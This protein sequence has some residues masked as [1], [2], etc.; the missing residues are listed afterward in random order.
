MA[1]REGLS[2]F[3][4]LIGE[5]VLIQL[6]KFYICQ[7]KVRE[8]SQRHGPTLTVPL[9]GV[10]VERKSTVFHGNHISTREKCT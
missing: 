6:R 8:Y 3:S 2:L 4:G 1:L 7:E 10:S 9:I 5:I